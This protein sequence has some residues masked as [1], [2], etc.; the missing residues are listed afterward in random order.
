MRNPE[1]APFPTDEFVARYKKAQRLM[2]EQGIDALLLTSK[3][4]V[5]YFSGLQTIG[6]DSKHR[7]L[8]VIIPRAEGREPIMVLA[9][10]LFYVARE[11]SWIEELRPWGGWRYPSAPSDPVIGIQQ[12]IAELELTKGTIGMELGY[13]Q[14]LG[15]SQSDYSMLV[16]GLPDANIVDMGDLLWQLRMIK[17]PREIEVIRKVCAATTAAFEAGFAAMRAG[18]TEKELA[19]IMFARM[20]EETN[21]RPGFMMVRSGPRKY[22]MVNVHPFN[23]PMNKGE[24]VVVDAGAT[25]KDYWADFMR[26]ASIGEPT[27]EQRRFFEADLE[28]QKVGVAAV[29]PG[30]PTREIFDASYNVLMETGFAEHARLERIGHGVGL[31]VHEPPSI[32]RGTTTIVQ[33]GMILT[34]EP[35]FSDQPNYQIGNFALEDVVLVTETGHEVLSLFP[36]ELHVVRT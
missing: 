13:G 14:R 11:T 26:M 5:I 23:K 35:I 33:P 17:S 10:T 31:D 20:A 29:K 24:L 28:S 34:V 7:P 30:I 25:Y 21:D 12:A 27:A 3:E 36:K 9:E 22:G 18:M 2:E 15:M 1:F 16:G 8:G 19:G 4:N 32:G 6:W